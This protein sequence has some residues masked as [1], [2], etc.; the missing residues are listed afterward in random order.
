MLCYSKLILCHIFNNAA[1]LGGV[2]WL[3]CGLG[4]RSLSFHAQKRKEYFRLSES[5]ELSIFERKILRRIYG[6][7]REGGQWRKRYNRE[8]EGLY[9]EPNI[10]NVIKSSRL[11]WAG[12]VVRMDDK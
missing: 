3:G 12:H 11:K 1:L 6:Q 8:L 7:L 5:V 2:W 10:V 9:N 4:D